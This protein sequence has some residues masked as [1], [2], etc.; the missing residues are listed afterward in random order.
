MASELKTVKTK[1]LIVNSISSKEGRM[2]TTVRVR[3]IKNGF[4]ITKETSGEDTKGHYQYNSEEF[5]SETNPL[6]IKTEDKSLAEL[7]E[8]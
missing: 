1:P 2:E 6:E 4:I 3:Q 8:K 7:F 5:Y